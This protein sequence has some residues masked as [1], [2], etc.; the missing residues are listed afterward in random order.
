MHLSLKS[1]TD[2]LFVAVKRSKRGISRISSYKADLQ[3]C[4]WL[5][6]RESAIQEAP[7]ALKG[8]QT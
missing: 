2:L 3:V 6:R 8:G 5:P 4:F 7:A 1:L